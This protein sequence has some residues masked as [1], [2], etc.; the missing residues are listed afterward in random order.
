MPKEI[1]NEIDRLEK[2]KWRPIC[3]IEKGNVVIELQLATKGVGKRIFA[4]RLEK[5]WHPA[6]NMFECGFYSWH[7]F[8]T[9]YLPTPEDR[10]ILTGID[11]ENH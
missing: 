10:R 7:Y 6:R 3:S 8:H 11:N 5:R 2:G 4:C 1:D 9:N